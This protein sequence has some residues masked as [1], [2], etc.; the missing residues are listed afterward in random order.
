MTKPQ[1][2]DVM[3]SPDNTSAQNGIE[4][5]E[6]SHLAYIGHYE[7][8]YVRLVNGKTDSYGKRGDFNSTKSPEQTINIKTSGN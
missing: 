8:F 1:V 5:L 3:G 2:I 7:Y 6:Y 4:Y